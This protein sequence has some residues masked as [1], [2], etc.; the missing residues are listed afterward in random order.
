[1]WMF[2]ETERNE[3]QWLLKV[4]ETEKNEALQLKKV[5]EAQRD[6]AVEKLNVY[7]TEKNKNYI[8]DRDEAASMAIVN[9][10]HAEMKDFD[11]E[12]LQVTGLASKEIN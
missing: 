12:A 4:S 8:S 10:V 6:E 1:M 7:V 2:F 5:S 11:K 9:A 3:A